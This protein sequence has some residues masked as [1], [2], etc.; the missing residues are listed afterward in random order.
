MSLR[1]VLSAVLAFEVVVLWLF[2]PVAVTISGLSAGVALPLGLGAGLACIVAIAL[3]RR[4]HGI[5]VGG[6]VQVLV[7]ALGLVV[8]AMFVIGGVFALLYFSALRLGR[9]IDEVRAEQQAAAERR[10][11]DGDAAAG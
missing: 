8:P 2:I 3:L 7:V 1:G 5:A 10:A 6:A 9:Q 4:P 11:A